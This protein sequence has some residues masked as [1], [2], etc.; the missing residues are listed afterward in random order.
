MRITLLGGFS[1]SVGSRTIEEGAWHLRKAANL[2]KLLALS[3]GHRMHREQVMGVLWPELDSRAAAN[4]LRYVLHVAR[5]TFDLDPSAASRYLSLHGEQLALCPDDQ[6]RVD[7]EAF[8]EAAAA[9]RR[10]RDPAAYRTAIELYTGELLPEDRYEEW[11]ESR[12]EELRRLHL[13]L[14]VELAGL[15]E[16]RGEHGPAVE[17]LRKVVAEE[18]TLEEA[19]TRLI[20]L[21][22]LSERRGEAMA[23]YGS[24]RKILS[25]KLSAQPSSA[26]RRLRD[27]IAAGEFPPARTPPAAPLREQAPDTSQHNL[28]AP[29]TS[30]VGREREMVEVKRTLAMTRLLT[31]TGA[32][33]SGKTRL[34]LE[35][36]KDLTSIYLDGVWLVELAPVSEVAL[37]PQIVAHTL[38]VR[39]V[40]GRSLTDTLVGALKTKQVLLLLDNCEHLIDTC[41]HFG[42]T[43][44][45][46]CPH[47]KIL[48]T[49]REPLG[50]AGEVIWRVPSL[51]TPST[52]RLPA[53]GELTRYDA[54]RLFLDRARLRLP[55]F[56]L[57]PGNAPAVADVCG[58]LEGI[59]LAIE[60]ATARVGALTVKEVAE[61]LEDSLGILGTS[62]RT[63][64]PRQQTMRATLEWSYRLLSQAER[65]LF[66]RLS[67]FAGGWTLKAAVVVGADGV[68]EDEILGL[69]SR[70]VDKS[71][72]VAEATASGETRYR[73]LETIR[74][75]GQERLQNSSESAP[76]HRRHAAFYL[77]MAEKAEL[78]LKGAQQEAWLAQLEVEH[79]NLRS[80]LSWTLEWEE[81]ELALRLCGALGE[82]WHMRGHLSEGR[83][84]LEA[85]L[86]KGDAPS[87]ARVKV[88]A[89]VGWIAWEQSDLQRSVALSEEGLALARRLGDK[90]GVAATLN[91]LGV[92]MLLQGELGRAVESFEESMPLL[93][94]LGDKQGLSCALL[95]LGAVAMIQG[96]YGQAMALQEEGLAAAREAGDVYMSML[97]L[98]HLGLVALQQEEYGRAEELCKQSL[99]AGRRSGMEHIVALS[100]HILAASAGWRG[101]PVRS[102]RLWGTAEVLRETIGA[103]LSPVEVRMY[104]PS[105]TAARDQ[106]GEVAW[107]AAWAEGRTMTSEQ[108]A[109]YALSGVVPGPPAVSAVHKKPPANEPLQV[110]TRRQEE[111]AAL[112]ARGLTNRQIATE[113]SISEHTVATHV[114]KIMR[115]LGLSSRSQLAVWVADQQGWPSSE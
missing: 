55:D 85:A 24:L 12:R 22:A 51:S 108:A 11:A 88:L 10:S 30:F 62:L 100:L 41:A 56:G 71:L 93:R 72:V 21:Y 107:E 9:A 69:L 36:A 27:E 19:H 29:R 35:V 75:Y 114:G 44:L 111:V 109:Q 97:A 90:S 98:N 64:T 58:R 34:A 18:P 52:D 47:L 20:R 39:E 26:T 104:G 14:L 25:E 54:V 102:A 78:E 91:N 5:R 115:K 59:P 4:N 57:T 95:G 1:V 66:K 7:V 48:A 83:R 31:L 76:V 42:D 110:L 13:A 86:A 53:A 68:Q 112:V 113:L 17:A 103:V 6:L 33:G 50:V 38:G 82:F 65:K 80:A 81:A 43:L 96:D 70:L 49:S 46:S 77:A 45:G 3:P 105:Q 16:E 61:R 73:M 101:Q 63:V 37:V 28:P 23:Q 89:K 87:V 92:A 67:V 74:Q 8:E 40:P 94:Q 106:L 32:G 99:E 84:W 2:V 15:Y 60:L 79:D